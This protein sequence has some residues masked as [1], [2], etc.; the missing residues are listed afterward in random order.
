MGCMTI[1]Q[2]Q[3]TATGRREFLGA[4]L[5]AIPLW[6]GRSSRKLGGI[7]FHVIR[8]GNSPR[9]YV[10]IHGDESTARQVLT[11]HMATAQGTAYLVENT[12]RNVAFQAGELDPNRMF[13]ADGAE[14]NMRRLNPDWPEAQILNGLLRL[15]RGRRQ[16]LAALRPGQGGVLIAAHNNRD[17]S[18]K[19]ELE[20]C[21]KTALNDRDNPHEFCLCTDERDF[22]VLSKGAYNVLLQNRPGGADDGSLSRRAVRDGFRYVNIEAAIG[23]MEKQRAML[24]WLDKVLPR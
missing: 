16:V 1:S 12:G 3:G 17:Y 5:G 2:Q 8:N 14:R 6:R 15:E 13:S 21:N 11:H 7:R 9:R 23:A 10:L 19:D 22:E 18:L 20:A 4:F 24:E